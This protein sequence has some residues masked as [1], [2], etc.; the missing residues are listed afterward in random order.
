[1][2]CYS[3]WTVFQGQLGAVSG[4]GNDFEAASLDQSTASIELNSIASILA[5]LE[6]CP[7]ARLIATE[8]GGTPANLLGL[9]ATSNGNRVF[10]MGLSGPQIFEPKLELRTVER[11]CFPG[12]KWGELHSRMADEAFLRTL[13]SVPAGCPVSLDYF[14]PVAFPSPMTLIETAYIAYYFNGVVFRQN[15]EPVVVGVHEAT[16]AAIEPVLIRAA[17]NTPQFARLLQQEC[18]EAEARRRGRA[19]IRTVAQQVLLAVVKA[20]KQRWQL[21]ALLEWYRDGAYHE[22]P[23]E[24]IAEQMESFSREV[25]LTSALLPENSKLAGD[26]TKV[27]REVI[28]THADP[29]LLV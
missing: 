16:L 29:I 24:P 19:A 23:P 10:A 4:E 28:A 3:R 26:L 1:M 25:E 6:D 2:K 9:Q 13:C 8:V 18:D 17:K 7:L 11:N 15:S 14:L 21:D 22:A 20:A 5:G 27:I 12:W